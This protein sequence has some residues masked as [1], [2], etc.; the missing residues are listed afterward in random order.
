MAIAHGHGGRH[1][2]IGTAR[3]PLF[4]LQLFFRRSHSFRVISIFSPAPPLLCIYTDMGVIFAL[5]FQTCL[6]SLQASIWAT[7]GGEISQPL[8]V[9]SAVWRMKAPIG[10]YRTLLCIIIEGLLFPTGCK[11]KAHRLLASLE[12]NACQKQ[13]Y[14]NRISQQ[15]GHLHED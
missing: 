14:A 8:T 2:T 1:S 12:H 11:V 9:W 5:W 13:E 10:E 3:L 7:P 6:Y 4:G 15:L